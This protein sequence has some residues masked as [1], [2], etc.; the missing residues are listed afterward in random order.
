MSDLLNLD[1]ALPPQLEVTW[2]GRKVIVDDPTLEQVL[3]ARQQVGEIRASG[4]D[5]HFSASDMFGVVEKCLA[6]TL[7]AGVDGIKAETVARSVERGLRAEFAERARK[8]PDLPDEP[9]MLAW[10][11]ETTPF[12]REALRAMPHHVY[13]TLVRRIDQHREAYRKGASAEDE[14]GDDDESSG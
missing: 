1:E 8:T 4:S 9:V 3:R 6:A 10:Y 7:E 2:Q 13:L 5:R 12:N 14:D 11:A